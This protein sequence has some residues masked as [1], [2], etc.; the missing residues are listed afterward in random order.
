[1]VYDHFHKNKLI[2]FNN[3]LLEVMAYSISAKETKTTP[4]QAVT[5]IRDFMFKWEE[6]RLWQ[7]FTPDQFWTAKL[8]RALDPRSPICY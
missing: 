6:Q 8:L 2:N 1:M 7:Q 5:K 4:I 3:S